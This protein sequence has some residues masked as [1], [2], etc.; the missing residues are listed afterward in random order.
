MKKLIDE[1]MT[2]LLLFVWVLW[3]GTAKY[4]IAGNYEAA[5]VAAGTAIMLI[6]L[7]FHIALQEERIDKR[8]TKE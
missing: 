6:C 4:A 5:A 8:I 2:V 1:I 3:L 7:E